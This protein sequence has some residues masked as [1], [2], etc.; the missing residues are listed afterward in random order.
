LER[1]SGVWTETT[2]LSREYELGKL[3]PAELVSWEDFLPVVAKMSASFGVDYTRER[4]PD[5]LK[6]QDLYL[7][8][9]R[10]GWTRK[11]LEERTADFLNTVRF[12]TW[13]RADFMSAPRVKVYPR[14]WY[15]ERTP[16]ERLQ[17]GAYRIPGLPKVVYGWLW[18]IGDKLERT[19][20]RKAV[21]LLA[22]SVDVAP[23]EAILPETLE[24][25]ERVKSRLELESELEEATLEVK[26][27]RATVRERE[28]EIEVLR[29][30]ARIYESDL[31]EIEGA[32]LQ[33]ERELAAAKSILER[34]NNNNEQ[35]TKGTR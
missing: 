9:R 1:A 19:D 13:T 29:K 8:L 23:P 17:I 26:R 30:T 31:L 4:T 3:L 16:E 35:T 27:L 20:N 5:A 6:I 7:E 10:Q 22:S 24:A 18:E 25:L 28:E 33:L 2:G 15:L 11:E 12:P 32:A 34:N 21:P 14:S